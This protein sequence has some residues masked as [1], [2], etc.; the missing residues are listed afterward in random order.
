MHIR[1]NWFWDSA[2][3]WSSKY[4]HRFSQD[5]KS[6][7]GWENLAWAWSAWALFS[8]GRSLGSCTARPLTIINISAR[9]PDSA[10]AST[11]RE[12]FG[13]MGRRAIFRPTAVNLPRPETAPS[14]SSKRRPSLTILPSGGST[15]GNFSASPRPSSNIFSS[16]AARLVRSSSGSV[17]SGRAVKSDSS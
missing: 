8:P 15:K 7:R 13:S 9:Q 2:C 3:R 12:S 4:C 10:A 11:M 16:T 6:E 5:R 17:N 1:R 14:S